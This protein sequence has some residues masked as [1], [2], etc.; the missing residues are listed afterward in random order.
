MTES[1]RDRIK[2]G[3]DYLDSWFDY[4]F[5]STTWPGLI[6]A[7]QHEDEL[8]WSQAYG[9][10]DVERE[11]PLTVG[12]Q[13]RIASQSK[14]FAATA[15]F[16]LAERGKLNVDDPVATHLGWFRCGTDPEVSRVTIRQLLS[17]GAGLTR[18]SADARFWDYER[19]FP[20][21]AEVREIVTT[22]RL[23]FSPNTRLKYSNI[24]FGV[25]GAVIE[26]ASGQPFGTF[27]REN[28]VTPL[29]LTATGAD[30][31]EHTLGNMAVGYGPSFLRAPRVVYP[32]IATS[33]LAPATGFYSTVADLGAFAAAHF[34]GNER[35]LTDASKRDMQKI[36]WRMPLDGQ[37]Y[38]SG[39]DRVKVGGREVIG[40]RGAFPGYMSCT[41]FDPETQLAI[42]V[43]VTAQDGRATTLAEAALGILDFYQH[44]TVDEALQSPPGLV[45]MSH[46]NRFFSPWGVTDIVAVDDWLLMV[47][48]S[49]LNPFD[50]PRVLQLSDP[51][52]ATIARDTGYGSAGELATFVR[53]D[54]GRIRS[55]T[56]AGLDNLRWDDYVARSQS[57]EDRT[58]PS[59][60]QP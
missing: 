17:H 46:A 28:I 60:R 15:I 44:P 51:D 31:D 38:A 7:V 5:R 55:V 26:A 14:M 54:S 52:S 29:G 11:I 50:S 16:I 40:H 39:L 35:L 36:Q 32:P 41:R 23:V 1:A 2:R 48:P 21:T 56:I 6:V 57:P 4:Q 10:A 43:A 3:T 30:V 37:D 19:P 24:G 22:S 33:A 45:S 47:D 20:T 27:V 58:E 34:M 9:L 25:L 18:D 13:F 12:H 8:V 49:V 53:D 42:S 59:N